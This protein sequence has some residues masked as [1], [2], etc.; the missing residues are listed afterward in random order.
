[1]A[2]NPLWQPNP[3]K[4]AK[5]QMQDFLNLVHQ[6]YGLAKKDYEHLHHWSDQNPADFWEEFWEYAKIRY[7]KNFDSGVD[8]TKKMPGAK[9]FEGAKLNYAENLLQRHDDK[10]AIIFRGEAEVKKQLSYKILSIL[11]CTIIL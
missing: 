10:T 3:E 2:Q 1:M 6:K 9:W 5:S 11:N 8:D 4:A 7:S